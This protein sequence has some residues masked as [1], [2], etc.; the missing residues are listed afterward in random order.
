MNEQ[1]DMYMKQR[2]IRS[3]NF[4][5]E[6]E[7]LLV[8]EV[9]KYKSIIECKATDK[10]SN[11]DKNEAWKKIESSF[12]AKNNSF[13]GVHQLKIKYDNLKMKTRKTIAE[14]K[15]SWIGI[16]KGPAANTVVDPVIETM[17]RIRNKDTAN[18]VSN[19]F[20]SDTSVSEINEVCV[21]ENI[22]KVIKDEDDASISLMDSK[23]LILPVE[24]ESVESSNVE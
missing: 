3:S 19:S 7:L 11:T 16:G 23:I 13:R 4:S 20:N 15:R 9:E 24:D 21:G 10:I 18:G 5:K 17:L 12:N 1:A 8:V 14:I 6:E 22:D 2:R